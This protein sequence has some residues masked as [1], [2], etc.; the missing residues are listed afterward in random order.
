MFTDFL[1]PYVLQA[2][3]AEKDKAQDRITLDIHSV[4]STSMPENTETSRRSVSI[5][6]K[7]QEIVE[8]ITYLTAELLSSFL[9]QIET[10]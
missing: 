2:K 7:S 6:S 5:I 1:S 4:P 9:Q 10:S 3:T 8:D